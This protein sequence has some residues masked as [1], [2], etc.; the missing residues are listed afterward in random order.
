M[1]TWIK[2][3]MTREKWKL[4]SYVEEIRKFHSPL[5]GKFWKGGFGVE[6][7]LEALM[8]QLFLNV[9]SI[10]LLCYNYIWVI[11]PDQLHV[12]LAQI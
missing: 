8:K 3:S 11:L 2:F 6:I 5:F 12:P 4:R 7:K 1:K 10:L 9:L